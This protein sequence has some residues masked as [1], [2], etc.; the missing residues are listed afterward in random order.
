[1]LMYIDPGTGSMLFSIAVGFIT[2]MYF[3]GKAALLKLKFLFSGGNR[4]VKTEKT[5]PVVI[6][7][8]GSRYWNVFSPVIQEF[9]KQRSPLLYL[10]SSEDDPFFS[11]QYTHVTGEFIGKGNKAFARLNRL[12]ADV[13]LMTTPGLDVYQLKRS[14]G[15]KHYAHVLHAPSDATT[16]RLFGLDYFDSVLL[17]GEYQKKDLRTLEELRGI[18]RKELVVVGCPY[19]DVLS[20]KVNDYKQ[21]KN[22]LFTVLVAPSWGESGILSR[23]GTIL[24]D[25]LVESGFQIIVRP[26]PQTLTSERLVLDTLIERYKEAQS[27]SWDFERENLESLSRA[28]ILISDFSGVVFDYSFLFNRPLLY[29]N[30]EFDERPYDSYDLESRP[31][32]FRI[33]PDLGRELL[34]SSFNDLKTIILEAVESEELQASRISA[35]NTAWQH[36]GE[37]GRR[38]YQ[39]LRE[40]Q[41][42]LKEI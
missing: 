27:L 13:C 7:S 6:Y 1:M 21:E 29:V 3:L 18:Q 14:K 25:P 26:H 40:K 28:D 34:P 39:F 38:M 12:E 2:M 36:E 22:Q 20:R 23:Y 24:L 10:T 16:Y 11:G 32:K 41:Q 35:R 5:L 42:E 33:L 17:S 4:A 31:W 30:A 37:S 19:L 9:E 15:V 8:E